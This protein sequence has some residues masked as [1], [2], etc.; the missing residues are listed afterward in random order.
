MIRKILGNLL[1]GT[2]M[3]LLASVRWWPNIYDALVNNVYKYYDFHITSAR[4]FFYHLFGGWLSYFVYALIYTIIILL[5]F[6]LIKDAY[7]RK[8]IHLSFV[9]KW[10]ILTAII[11]GWILLV[12]MFGNI[13]M[14]PMWYNVIY[15]LFALFASFMLT[16]ILYFIIDLYYSV[17]GCSSQKKD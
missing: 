12:G 1:V 5:P 3:P 13:W 10:F 17:E 4:E 14:I 9:K 6:Q 15:I 8:L 2:L 7:R 11:L 16:G